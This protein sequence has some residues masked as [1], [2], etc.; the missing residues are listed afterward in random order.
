MKILD[1]FLHFFTSLF[2]HGSGDA[3]QTVL[4][5]V[6]GLATK[7]EPI[8]LEIEDGLKKE[9]DSGDH[10]KVLQSIQNYLHKYEPDLKIVTDKANEL[11][12][13]PKA[14]LLLGVAEFALGC[15]MP[16]VASHWLRLAIEFA[17]SMMQAKKGTLTD[18]V[19]TVTAQTEPAPVG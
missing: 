2:G 6:A 7:A 9:L 8:V 5:G 17:Y 1:G 3:A 4:H 10:N 12:M 15:F 16:G 13:Q 18:P 11:A 19:M 14:D